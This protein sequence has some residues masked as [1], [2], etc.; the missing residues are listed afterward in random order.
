MA[1][2]RGCSKPRSRWLWAVG[3]RRLFRRA[4][5]YMAFLY[6]FYSHAWSFVAVWE[7]YPCSH[8]L[9]LCLLLHPSA[10]IIETLLL[11]AK[12]REEERTISGSTKAGPATC[13]TFRRSA[14]T[15]SLLLG[16]P[17][18]SQ[19]GQMHEVACRN[20]CWL[21]GFTLVDSKQFGAFIRFSARIFGGEHMI[22]R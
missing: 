22:F 2:K 19:K 1:S 13:K 15:F 4:V 10:R 21:V 12:L 7:I 11:A 5:T 6:I 9:S 20:I 17:G 18:A 3:I 14:S 16:P 8:S